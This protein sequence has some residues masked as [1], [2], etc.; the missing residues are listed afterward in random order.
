[1]SN[2]SPPD[3]ARAPKQVTAATKICF[4]ITPMGTPGSATRQRALHVINTYL[5]PACSQAGYDARS[6]D[7]LDSTKIS[8]GIISALSCAPMTI[9]YLGS[10]PWNDDV[11]VELGYRLAS[12][13]P[14]VVVC[15]APKDGEFLRFPMIIHDL[16]RIEIP[17]PDAPD[18]PGLVEE[19]VKLIRASERESSRVESHH[20]IALVHYHK[21]RSDAQVN[22]D[23]M[24]YIAASEKATELFGIK[25][26][27]GDEHHLVG[28]TLK[29]FLDNLQYRMPAQH[30]D[31][32]RGSQDAATTTWSNRIRTNVVL[33][34]SVDVPIV[35]DRHWNPA[36]VGRA[37]LPVIVSEF[38]SEDKAW[39]N[40]KVLYLEVTAHTEGKA[41]QPEPA[42]ESDPTDTR[43]F[44][45]SLANDNRIAFVPPLEPKPIGVFFSYNSA[46]HVRVEQLRERLVHLSP[47]INIW[48]DRDKIEGADDVNGKL[49]DGINMA[50]VAAVIIGKN[51][52]GDW[53][54][55]EVDT[56]IRQ[57]A[58][59]GLKVLTILLDGIGQVELPKNWE[60][61]KNWRCEAIDK[62]D[63]DRYLVRFFSSQFGERFTY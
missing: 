12:G 47:S 16:A 45:C 55:Q 32:F 17:P 14:L 10:P 44:I 27:N 36:Y 63:D 58:K 49:S 40:L 31:V 48:L 35:F 61:L 3:V 62:V 22:A 9:A 39:C 56:I 50:D 38:R 13:L 19:L 54:N 8:S 11:M 26:D 42:P 37:Y 23:E 15:N 29:E 7:K 60:L 43:Y 6:S 57:N 20:P 21:V 18:D 33:P 28:H 34:P 46:D 30:Y 2:T 1:M 25:A 51:G 24:H 5:R 4:V 59:R 52:P 53:Q 41:T